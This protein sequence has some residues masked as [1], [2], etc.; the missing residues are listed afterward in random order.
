M[1]QGNLLTKQKGTHGLED[2]VWLAGAG[3][4]REFGEVMCTL[5]H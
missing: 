3:T 2:E 5:L 4:V 1:I